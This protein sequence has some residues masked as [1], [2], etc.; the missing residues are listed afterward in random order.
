MIN[1]KPYNRSRSDA[2]WPPRQGVSLIELIVVIATATILVGILTPLLVKVVRLESRVHGA[3]EQTRGLAKL[4]IKMREDL[5]RSTKA[6]WT[7]A[8]SHA[9]TE[10]PNSES[11]S[12][13]VSRSIGSSG[14]AMPPATL[15]LILPHEQI[16][17]ELRRAQIVRIRKRTGD[18]RAGHADLRPSLEGYRTPSNWH[19]DFA[20]SLR[21]GRRWHEL[22]ATEQ[23]AEMEAGVM[24]ATPSVAW[25]VAV[26]A[27]SPHDRPEKLTDEWP[28]DDSGNL[29]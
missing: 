5:K 13:G 1:R 20:S 2:S 3:V 23:P 15:E 19:F 26:A 9:A 16:R 25:R 6:T 4:A 14:P 11:P 29:P 24:A 8:P 7:E 18:N 21:N 22:S 28:T 27:P 10:S 17:Y 12:M